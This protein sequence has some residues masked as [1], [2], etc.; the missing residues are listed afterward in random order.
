MLGYCF[1]GKGKIFR[2][3]HLHKIPNC[4]FNIHVFKTSIEKFRGSVANTGLKHEKP[5]TRIITSIRE[6]LS[7]STYIYIWCIYPIRDLGL[8]LTKNE[9][10]RTVRRTGYFIYTQNVNEKE[11]LRIAPLYHPNILILEMDI[12]S[13]PCFDRCAVIYSSK[14]RLFT[15]NTLKDSHIFS[16]AKFVWKKAPICV[17]FFYCFSKL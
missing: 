15:Q 2:N 17:V 7:F 13:R 6:T 9:D 16:V 12:L 10:K 14:D 1:L 3:A 11:N 8:V 4:S 5:T